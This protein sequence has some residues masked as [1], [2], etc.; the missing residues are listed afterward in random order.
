MTE[1]KNLPTLANIL[2]GVNIP[3]VKEIIETVLFEHPLFN[4]LPHKVISGV[5]YQQKARTSIPLFGATPYNTGVTATNSNYEMRSAECYPYQG[6][7]IVDKKIVHADPQNAGSYMQHELEGKMSGILA[8]LEISAIYGKAVS[9]FGMHGLVDSIGD[10]MTA[11][12]TGDYNER[13]HGGASV[14]ALNL[15]SRMMHVVWGNSKTI[16]FGGQK[17]QLVPMPDKDGKP[18]YM[19]AYTRDIDFHV[20]FA[21]MDEHATARLVNESAEHP[22]TDA[23]LADLVNRFP[24]GYTPDVLVMSRAT[25]QR[26]QEQR[27][28]QYSYVKKVSGH[29][30]Y[31]ELPTDFEGIPIITTDALLPDETPEAIDALARKTELRVEYDKNTSFIR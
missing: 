15:K 23:M 25:R 29:T 16:A 21:Q 27:A 19:P 10:Y 17:E 18:G 12:A 3:Y 9:P 1:N 31:A 24:T 26:L 5:R 6:L 8:T 11:T 30:A 20:G 4:Q 22:L 14:W 7:A 2:Q 13:V 28:K